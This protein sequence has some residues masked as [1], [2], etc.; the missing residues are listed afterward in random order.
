MPLSGLYKAF[1][2]A[3]VSI[4]VLETKCFLDEI[5]E[6]PPHRLGSLT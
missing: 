1:L 6:R 3:F 2:A 5:E 4:L